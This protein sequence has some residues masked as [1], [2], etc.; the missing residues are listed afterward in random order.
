MTPKEWAVVVETMN[1]RWPD[2]PRSVEWARA[3]WPTVAGQ[4]LGAVLAGLEVYGREGAGFPPDGGQLARLAGEVVDPEA[5]DTAWADVQRQIR[6]EGYLGSPTFDDPALAEVVASFGWRT[7]C[8]VD[9]DNLGTARAQLR[10]MWKA[11][12]Q[13]QTRSRG[14][15]SLPAGPQREAI[16]A[17]V[18]DLGQRLAI[19]GGR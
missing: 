12:R 13:R 2:R 6:R 8:A 3:W 5:W 17:V 18:G 19:G 15:A 16:E 4:E 14:L 7:L 1:E 10:D 9:E 11:A